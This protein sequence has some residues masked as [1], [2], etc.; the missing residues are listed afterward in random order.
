[1]QS[2]FLTTCFIYCNQIEELFMCKMTG[3]HVLCKSGNISNTR[4]LY[5]VEWHNTVFARS[6]PLSMHK[7]FTSCIQR[8]LV[9]RACDWVMSALSAAL[10]IFSFQFSRLFSLILTIEMETRHPVERVNLGSELP[11]ICNHCGVMTAW[12]RKIWKFFEQCLRFFGKTT[13]YGKVF[14]IMFRKFVP[15]HWSTLLCWKF[16]E[17]IRQEI[18]EIVRYLPDK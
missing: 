9:S 14:K 1:M 3:G 8:C 6:G 16:V 5:R 2:N 13:P 10:L 11:V 12:S 7:L 15:P 4:R 18:G 17:F